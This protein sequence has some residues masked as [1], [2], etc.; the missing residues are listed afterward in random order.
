MPKVELPT[1]P[2]EVKKTRPAVLL[3]YGATKVGKTA[4]L[5]DLEN[6]LIIDLERGA[7]TYEC[8]RVTCNS[9]EDFQNV[10]KQLREGHQYKYVTIDTIDRLV[11]WFEIDVKDEWNEAQ[12]NLKE[13]FIVKVYSEIPYGKGYDLVRLKM[14]TFINFM[15]R[16]CPHTILIGHLKRTII[17]E[18]RIEVKED[19]LDLVGKLKN[20]VC[21]DADA[22]GYAFRGEDHDDEKPA[23]KVSFKTSESSAAGSRHKHL[24]GKTIM[25]SKMIEEDVYE[26]YWNLIYPEDE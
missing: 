3:L 20:L 10:L 24:R 1:T 16:V 12:K 23:L 9:Y 4:V 22:V 26:S 7:E 13:K 8:L 19:N 14:R 15:R 6:N 21:A 17:G 25:L 11:E 2:V 18:T 5:A